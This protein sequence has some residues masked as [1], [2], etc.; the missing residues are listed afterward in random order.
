MSKASLNT[1]TGKLFIVIRKNKEISIDKIKSYC[2]EYSTQYAFICHAKDVDYATGLVIPIHYHI[3][4][5]AKDTRKRLST[6]L[7]D[8]STFFG[9]KNNDGIEIDKYRS[10]ESGL[11]YLIHKNDKQ[12][13]QHDINEIITNI[14]ADEL[15]TYLTCNTFVLSFDYIYSLCLSSRN[16][17]EIIKAIGI[18]NYQ[19]YRATI[20]DIWNDTKKISSRVFSSDCSQKSQS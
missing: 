18:S 16:I 13:T 6:H 12:K 15:K 19:R 3:I 5:N 11:Q 2:K 20:W 17:C 8:L 7:N 10:W 4:M 14:D 1:Q 9:F